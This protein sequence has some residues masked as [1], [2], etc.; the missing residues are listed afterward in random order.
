MW[1]QQAFLPGWC[2]V[3]AW[4]CL[5][6]E[7]WGDHGGDEEDAYTCTLALHI[8]PGDYDDDGDDCDYD[9]DDDYDCSYSDGGNIRNATEDAYTV[10]LRL[11]EQWW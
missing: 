11:N 9:D 3:V 2:E 8:C 6:W 10:S 7:H 1:F 5:H 4:D